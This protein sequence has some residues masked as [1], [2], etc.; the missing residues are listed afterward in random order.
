[1]AKDIWIYNSV[2]FWLFT[3]TTRGVRLSRFT[4]NAIF[5]TSGL[6]AHVAS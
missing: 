6:L 5:G 1:M 3:E 2:N 4:V